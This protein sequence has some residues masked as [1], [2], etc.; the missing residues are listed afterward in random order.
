MLSSMETLSQH[1]AVKLAEDRLKGHVN[2][3]LPGARVWLFGSRALGKEQ[4]RSDFD[5]AVQPGA[6]TP[7]SAL[8]EFEDAIKADLE[9]IY[10]V[11][12]VD[13]RMAPAELREKVQREGIL[14]KN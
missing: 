13:F 11:D 10:P 4:R 9:I 5:L 6:E 14:W 7:E 1:P 2:R 8:W 3:L 12:V